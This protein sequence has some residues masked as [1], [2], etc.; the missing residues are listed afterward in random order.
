MN[1][2]SAFSISLFPLN[3]FFQFLYYTDSGSTFFILASYYLLLQKNYQVSA[4]VAAIAILYRQTNVIWLGFLLSL[5]LISNMENLLGKSTNNTQSSESS[6]SIGKQNLDASTLNAIAQ[7]RSK[8]HST[9]V[10]FVS[11]TPNEAFGQKDFKI[12]KLIIKVYREDLTGKKLL[13]SELG[14]ILD[15]AMIQP[16]VF[17]LLTFLF[18][19]FVNKGIVVGDKENHLA[20]FHLVQMFYF[21]SFSCCFSFSSF[22][23]SPKKLKNFATFFSSNITLIFLVIMPL[24]I[25]ITNKFSYEHPFLLADNRH[26]TFYLWSK[27]FRRHELIKYLLAPIYFASIYLFYRNLTLTGKSIAWLLAFSVCL[28]AALIPQK[29]IEFRYFIIP[30]YIYRLNLN[31]T[32]IKE[33]LVE[34]IFNALVNAAT[35]YIFFNKTFYWPDNSVEVQRFMW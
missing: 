33:V 24:F 26:F 21:F 22:L 18:F 11:K 29:L 28:C 2:L 4:Y 23:F 5:V 34:L 17:I 19:V 13:Y 9:L 31:Q 30:Y 8:K 27:L 20:S 7:N 10:E 14:K 3:Y 12:K 6:K 16:F 35:I 25:I 1:V 15:F 32:S